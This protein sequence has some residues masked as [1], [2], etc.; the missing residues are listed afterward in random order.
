MVTIRQVA[1]QA[2]VSIGTVSRVLNHKP[3]VSDATREHVSGVAREMGYSVPYRAPV[4]P[5]NISR[6]GLL[7]PPIHGGL[8]T[9]PFYHDVF[10]GVEQ[11]CQEQQIKLSFNTLDMS[12]ISRAHLRSHPPL[13]KDENLNGLVLVGAMQYQVVSDLIDACPMPVVLVDNH[14]VESPWD[15]IM[16]DNKRGM[17]HIIRHLVTQGHRHIALLSGPEHPS[18]IERRNSYEQTMRAYGLTPLIASPPDL[19]PDSAEQCVLQLLEQSPELTA[20]ACSNDLQAIA[21]S[22][23]L[24]ELN[25]AVPADFSVTGFDDISLTEYASPPI[26]TIRVD[27]IALG[28]L[29]VEILL[30]RI[31]YPQKP[32]LCV[33]IGIN[34][35]ERASVGPARPVL[36]QAAA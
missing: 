23:K 4:S 8:L 29:A 13:L 25:Y 35:C 33:V 5:A 34:F 30:S 14:F 9:N 24:Q 31:K 2:G 20:F 36:A 1:N 26:T 21:V 12:D 19:M 27:R 10:L 3:G 18:I 32:P 11:V 16:I 7:N 22:K 28:R 17:E 6:L 15:S